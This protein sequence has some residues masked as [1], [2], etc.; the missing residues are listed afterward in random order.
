M[1]TAHFRN[2]VQMMGIILLVAISISEHSYKIIL[3]H[4]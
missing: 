2:D 1:E 3:V 4:C